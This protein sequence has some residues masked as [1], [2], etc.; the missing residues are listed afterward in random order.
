PGPPARRPGRALGPGQRP[1]V[2]WDLRGLPAGQGRQGLPAVAGGGALSTLVR[3][4]LRGSYGWPMTETRVVTPA[5]PLAI[6]PCHA[7]T[8]LVDLPRLATRCGVARVVL[9]DEGLRPIGSF[10]ALGGMYAGLRALARATGLPDF[11]SLVAARRPRGS[12]PALMCA[13][14]GNHGLAVAAAAELAGGPPPP[15]LHRP[16]PPARAAGHAPPP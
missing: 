9:K 2:R 5:A 15:R 3:A 11:E 10:K 8:P 1:R 6:W 13:S 14:D 12:L 16:P 4:V 7:P